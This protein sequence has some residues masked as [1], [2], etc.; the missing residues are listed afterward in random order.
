MSVILCCKGVMYKHKGNVSSDTDTP[1]HT[2]TEKGRSSLHHHGSDHRDS[3][4]H[5]PLH[6]IT[7]T[8]VQHR[9]DVGQHVWRQAEGA[10]L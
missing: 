4:Y 6:S 2:H 9:R 3:L 10:H 1:K 8:Q 7:L 5:L